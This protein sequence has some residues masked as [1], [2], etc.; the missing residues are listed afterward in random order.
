MPNPTHGP[1]TV[2]SEVTFTV[3]APQAAPADARQKQKNEKTRRVK[4]FIVLL[5]QKGE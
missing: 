4:C 3:E 2:F 5:P 1:L